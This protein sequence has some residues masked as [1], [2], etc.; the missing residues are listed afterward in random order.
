MKN[1][2]LFRKNLTTIAVLYSVVGA[3]LFAS[4]FILSLQPSAA[5]IHRFSDK[6]DIESIPIDEYILSAWL[7]KPIIIFRPSER[8]I[9]RL[10]TKNSQTIGVKI[11]E[12]DRP[13]VFVYS[14]ASSYRGC[15]V[16]NVKESA[17][18]D[19]PKDWN[20]Q[21]GWLDPCHMEVYQNKL[22]N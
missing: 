10:K 3:L 15:T 13:N 7:G 9:E 5:A 20:W 21:G 6:Y 18:R 2:K 17:N 1:S 22:N 19:F 8:T 12:E 4:P 11:S 16:Y 14:A